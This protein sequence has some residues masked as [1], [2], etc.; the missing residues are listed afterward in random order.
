MDTKNLAL[1]RLNQ[2]SPTLES[3]AL[4]L[5]EEAGEL[6][7]CIGKYRGLSGEIIELDEA[8]VVEE[9][10]KELLDVAQTAVTMMFV[11]E[12]R[13]GID[14]DEMLLKHMEKLEQKGYLSR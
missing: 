11:M 5:M 1:P 6:A 14:I 8:T 12:E 3:T 9:I 7:Q 10:A 4:K 2:L 13:F